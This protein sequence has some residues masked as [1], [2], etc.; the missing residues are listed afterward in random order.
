MIGYWNKN[1][2]IRTNNKDV[3]LSYYKKENSI[4]ISIASW[5]DA[6]VD[7]RIEADWESLGYDPSKF[8]FIAPEIKNFQPSASFRVMEKIPVNPLKGWLLIINN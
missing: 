4:L 7:I 8:E 5:A 3:L 6:P 2:E 1:S